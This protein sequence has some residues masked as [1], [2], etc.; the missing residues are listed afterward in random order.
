MLFTA[1]III[2]VLTTLVGVVYLCMRKGELP[3]HGAREAMVMYAFGLG[4]LLGAG[5]VLASLVILAMRWL[6]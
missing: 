4:Y 1:G 3:A 6:P 2:L 5:C